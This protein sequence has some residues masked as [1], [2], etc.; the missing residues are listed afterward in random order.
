MCAESAEW[1]EPIQTALVEAVQSPDFAVRDLDEHRSGQ[2]YAY[3]TLWRVTD[4]T[5]ST[6]AV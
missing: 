4:L 6:T 2:D 1:R 5:S 3:D